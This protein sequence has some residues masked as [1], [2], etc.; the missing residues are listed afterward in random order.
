[1]FCYLYANNIKIASRSK[2][3]EARGYSDDVAVAEKV[4]AGLK[5]NSDGLDYVKLVHEN[6]SSAEIY[7]FG[8][9]VTC[10]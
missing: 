3:A 1:M 9:D 6:G 7:L 5:T 2:W 4:E 8:G 10:K